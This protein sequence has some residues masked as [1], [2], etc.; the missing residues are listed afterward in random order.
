MQKYL[1]PNAIVGGVIL[2]AI[3]LFYVAM[4]GAHP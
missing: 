3:I 2:G 4:Y 1:I